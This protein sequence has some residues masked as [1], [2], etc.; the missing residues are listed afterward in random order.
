MV[1]PGYYNV[2]VTYGDS[3]IAAKHDIII[4][5]QPIA[6]E[7][8]LENQFATKTLENL[9]IMSGEIKMTAKCPG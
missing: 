3:E 9:N 7:F 1:T 2:I 6:G 4:N 5:N 8:L